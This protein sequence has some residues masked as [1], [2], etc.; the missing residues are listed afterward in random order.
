MRQSGAW[1][2]PALGCCRGR[3]EGSRPPCAAAPGTRER[4]QGPQPPTH[5]L[6]HRTVIP[7][8]PQVQAP[9][10]PPAS[11]FRCSGF[12]RN[13]E[14]QAEGGPMAS[15]APRAAARQPQRRLRAPSCYRTKS[16]G[17]SEPGRALCRAGSSGT[18]G[19]LAA[20]LSARLAV[21]RS[22]RA[23]HVPAFGSHMAGGRS[24]THRPQRCTGPH[25]GLM[26][27]TPHP[28]R[29]RTGEDPAPPPRPGPPPAALVRAKG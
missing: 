1:V 29:T 16:C 25:A 18:T 6:I 21:G 11:W 12:S 24:R 9:A 5:T 3:G 19:A 20:R 8:H 17:I 26:P 27:H 10:S 14:A 23:W 28:P 4:P 7:Q 15:S 2:C 22:L 13:S